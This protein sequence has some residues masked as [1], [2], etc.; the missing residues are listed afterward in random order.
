MVGILDFFLCFV[1]HFDGAEVHKIT[2]HAK[3]AHLDGILIDGFSGLRDNLT[4]DIELGS[5][6][7]GITGYRNGLLESTG[8]SIGVIRYRDVAYLT[9]LNRLM[10][11]V[12]R[13]A[14]ATRPHTAQHERYHAFVLK[15]KY[16]GYTTVF[17]M[18]LTEIVCCFLKSNYR[19]LSHHDACYQ[20]Q[21]H[22]H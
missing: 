1:T 22:W 7:F 17:L 2:L 15:L 10:R 4:F 14:T 12:R 21:R 13:R 9:G 11:P 5:R 19:L 6:R 16:C 8:T 18:N 3:F 20:Q